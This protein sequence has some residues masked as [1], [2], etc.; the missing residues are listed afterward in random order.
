MEIGEKKTKK[1]V[2]NTRLTVPAEN[3]SVHNAF[4][5]LV[6]FLSHLIHVL[7]PKHQKSVRPKD[8]IVPFNEQY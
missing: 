7:N 4:H 2:V 5:S 8:G 1:A 3:N 6:F